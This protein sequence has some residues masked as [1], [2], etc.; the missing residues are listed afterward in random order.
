M[1]DTVG[2]SPLSLPL[3]FSSVPETEVMS[4]LLGNSTTRLNPPWPVCVIERGTVNERSLPAVTIWPVALPAAACPLAEKAA[5]KM[6]H[7]PAWTI[8]KFAALPQ[9]TVCDWDA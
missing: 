1:R 5:T 4:T 2:V 6:S 3:A 9:D 8:A 7:V